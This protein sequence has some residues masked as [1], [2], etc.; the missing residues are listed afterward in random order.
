MKVLVSLFLITL[1][2][3][4]L[5]Q[6]IEK[7]FKGRTF[8]PCKTQVQ[9]KRTKCNAYVAATEKTALIAINLFN[10]IRTSKVS[11][12]QQKNDIQVL[13]KTITEAINIAQK[14][15]DCIADRR[16][17]EKNCVSVCNRKKRIL[18]DMV[19]KLEGLKRKI[20]NKRCDIIILKV[21]EL[22][23][24]LEELR[25]SAKNLSRGK[26]S[27]RVKK[28][29]E[30]ASKLR[31]V[32][33]KCRNGA[34]FAKCFKNVRA[35]IHPGIPE[36][37]RNAALVLDG[38]ARIAQE[39]LNK[40]KDKKSKAALALIAEKNKYQLEV[41]KMIVP[42]T[43]QQCQINID[44]QIKAA[45]NSI[46]V[47]KAQLVLIKDAKRVAQLNKEI[48]QLEENIETLKGKRFVCQIVRSR[49]NKPNCKFWGRKAERV[50]RHLR[51]AEKKLFDAQQEKSSSDQ[52][53]RVSNFKV[54]ITQRTNK[55]KQLEGQLK[56]CEALT[57]L[58][59]SCKS[60]FRNCKD[61]SRECRRKQCD[62][63]QKKSVCAY[64]CG[65][66]RRQCNI[67]CAKT[68]KCKRS[69]FEERCKDEC[70]DSDDCLTDC[71][72]SKDGIFICK[73]RCSRKCKKTCRR[74]A[75]KY[76]KRTNRYLK[77]RRQDGKKQYIEYLLS[78]ITAQKKLG[79]SERLDQIEKG[80]LRKKGL[81]QRNMDKYK[82]DKFKHSPFCSRVKVD[83]K[84]NKSDKF[85]K[86]I[87]DFNAKIKKVESA[88]KTICS[89]K[90]PASKSPAKRPSAK[91]PSAKKPS[92][93][94]PARKAK[95]PTKPVVTG[96][97]SASGYALPKPIISGQGSA[98]GYG[99][100]AAGGVHKP[101]VPT[102]VKPKAQQAQCSGLAAAKA[103]I[104]ELY[105]K[106]K[107]LLT[108]N[109]QESDESKKIREEIIKQLR[110]TR[111]KYKNCFN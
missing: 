91:K 60:C 36:N 29:K 21:R 53:T 93:K 80:L 7:S 32:L 42:S 49:I 73:Q 69:S 101:P 19:T 34:P 4:I 30:M 79:K 103:S 76:L 18:D 90:R 67:K 1:F 62:G 27:E 44:K 16:D 17:L 95:T 86:I 78:K 38:K 47:K 81:V 51:D 99:S 57:K 85:S 20:G 43:R 64:R 39:K 108:K 63:N 102:V 96:Q 83:Y 14:A 61:E 106:R 105:N 15:T 66:R 12:H 54:V 50:K 100:K 55:L 94:K 84:C 65:R 9:N 59:K 3:V 87:A 48:K 31:L 68:L 41:K 52:R 45:Q 23:G 97:G 58:K 82:C 5:S 74:G 98:S 70:N 37:K 77:C 10:K 25:D 109:S 8:V 88:K 56:K 72:D 13:L 71:K 40:I 110:E 26:S 33:D 104:Q 28:V 24:Q 75:R 22:K 6:D 2:G 46:G 92:T 107:E 35:C 111:L 89:A 11:K